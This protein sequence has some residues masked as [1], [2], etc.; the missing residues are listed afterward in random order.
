MEL[1]ERA[2]SRRSCTCRNWRSLRK[3]KLSRVTHLAGRK[4]HR[5]R[6]LAETYNVPR[7][8]TDYTAL[9]ADNT[10]DGI[11][12]ALP[13]PLHVR[14]GLEVL[15]AGKHLYMQKPLCADMD[16][17]N[18]FVTA[19]ENTDRIVYC[20]PHFGPEVYACR[21]LIQDGAIGKPSGAYCRASHGG[22][23]VYYA[24]IRDNFGEA[25]EGLWFF[26]PGEAAVGALFDMG[27]Y[28]V[29][30]L[31]AV[32]GSVESVMGL[33]ATIDKPTSL[34]DTATLLL[35]FA[36]GALGTAETGWCDPSRTGQLR[37]HGTQGKLASPGHENMRLTRWEPGSYTRED[38]PAIPHNIPLAKL[39]A[40]RLACGM[41][42]LHPRKPPTRTQPR[43][44]RPPRHRNPACR[45]AIRPRRTP[46]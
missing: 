35:R 3:P 46:N 33:T 26:Q 27:V 16:E 24:E 12:V 32:M 5:L 38:E 37:I 28:A 21:Q 19:V 43:P 36:N 45:P 42:A 23:E 34:E 20:L 17:A 31:V 25:D 9:F 14:V 39:R 40:R 13:H 6:L 18:A 4:E 44:R 15:E 10:L 2:G 22:P 30:S 11:I 7:W 8:T 29:A 1:L 41:A